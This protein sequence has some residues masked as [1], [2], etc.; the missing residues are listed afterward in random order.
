MYRSGPYSLAAIAFF[1]ACSL[2]LSEIPAAA[3]DHSVPT[4]AEEAAAVL[5]THSSTGGGVQPLNTLA[6]GGKGRPAFPPAMFAA[7]EDLSKKRIADDPPAG[8]QSDQATP[9]PAATGKPVASGVKPSGTDRVVAPPRLQTQRKAL[10]EQQTGFHA[11]RPA[12]PAAKIEALRERLQHSPSLLR[13]RGF[14]RG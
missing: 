2:V 7:L 6:D 8:K 12:G 13:R 9:K 11:R 4:P 5:E 14:H 3:G 10:P 1:A